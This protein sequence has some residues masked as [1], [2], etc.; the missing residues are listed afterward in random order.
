MDK[1]EITQGTN[2]ILRETESRK[3]ISSEC[4]GEGVIFK[5]GGQGSP[6]R[7]NM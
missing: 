1:P 5:E 6:G 4:R 7:G 2:K 3:R